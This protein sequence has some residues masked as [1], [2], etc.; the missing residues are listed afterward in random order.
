[1]L[2]WQQG[3]SRDKRNN[4]RSNVALGVAA[5]RA[6]GTIRA[7]LKG[8][9]LQPDALA[10]VAVYVRANGGGEILAEHGVEVDG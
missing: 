6:E 5:E 7:W 8:G 4:P 1:V 3:G 10:R 2:A 9:G